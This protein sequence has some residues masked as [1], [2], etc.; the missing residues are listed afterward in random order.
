MKRMNLVGAC[1]V[2]LLAA[3]LGSQAALAQ[4]SADTPFRDFI[5]SRD[6]APT[7]P[8]L[9]AQVPGGREDW[10]EFTANTFTGAGATYIEELFKHSGSSV[11]PTS[12]KLLGN[13]GTIYTV[14][15]E[16]VEIYDVV[17]TE[18]EREI[19]ANFAGGGASIASK[20]A[21]AAQISTACTGGF[22]V[23]FAVGVAASVAVDLIVE[24]LV[25]GATRAAHDLVNGEPV[26]PFRR[27][28]GGGNG[29]GTTSGSQRRPGTGTNGGSSAGNRGPSGT[30][31]GPRGPVGGGGSGMGLAG[32][33]GGG[34]PVRIEVTVRE[35]STLADGSSATALGEVGVARTGDADVRVTADRVSTVAE[36]GADVYTG[37]GVSNSAGSDAEARVK[38]VTTIGERGAQVTASYGIASGGGK[39]EAR[40]TGDA[41]T[42]GESG[43]KA[44]TAVGVATAGGRAVGDIRGDVTTLAGR[45]SS[46][47]TLVGVSYGGSARASVRGDVTTIG[48]GGANTSTRIGV[49]STA[50]VTGDVINQNGRLSIGNGMTSRHGRLCITVHR[51]YCVYAMAPRNKHGC[52]PR[53][54]AWGG[55]CY[56]YS[57]K[58]HRLR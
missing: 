39:A 13:F 2:G 53:F 15:A 41:T 34:G 32:G 40:V 42:I 3:S 45:G 12:D 44:E 5:D 28:S 33:N 20:I 9:R 35:V 37:I 49:N 22:L 31:R 54:E 7:P 50:Y 27:S 8:P 21:I 19:V 48:K 57:D 4:D 16:A 23:C 29:S 38:D 25:E 26:S 11:G 47:E 10:G 36:T 24:P 58:R 14:G 43:S 51:G 56:L 30:N 55:M 52:P 1:A 46:V 18:D 17:R 6:A